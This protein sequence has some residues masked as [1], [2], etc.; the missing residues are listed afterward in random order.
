MQSNKAFNEITNK[1]R[2]YDEAADIH[3]IK[4]KHQTDL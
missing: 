4:E 1:T 2:Q 3:N